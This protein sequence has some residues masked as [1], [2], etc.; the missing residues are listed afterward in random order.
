MKLGE[1]FVDLKIKGGKEGKKELGQTKSAFS[2]VRSASLATKAAIV[3]VVLG[4][5]KLTGWAGKTGQELRA[6]EGATNL[7]AETLQKWQYLGRR[8]GVTGED[9]MNSIS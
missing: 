4:L 6:F 7:S 5:Q 9:M 8:F 1:L 3:G 2:Q